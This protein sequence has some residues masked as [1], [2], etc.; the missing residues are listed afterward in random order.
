MLEIC[1][2]IY[3]L[4][5]SALFIYFLLL[6]DQTVKRTGLPEAD[7]SWQC[8][9]FLISGK[10]SNVQ[11]V[12]IHAHMLLALAGVF[13]GLISHLASARLRFPRLVAKASNS[14]SATSQAASN[15]LLQTKAAL[16]KAASS[17]RP[18]VGIS[19]AIY[20]SFILVSL[21]QP[22]T[23]ASITFLPMFPI[24]IRWLAGAAVVFDIYGIIRGLQM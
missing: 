19:G 16:R 15:V 22:T 20:A 14:I 5:G 6:E 8:F 21:A 7:T 2:L 13:S 1:Y 24:P 12:L 10:S 4:T 11:S 17:I 9:A 18:S 3:S 23:L